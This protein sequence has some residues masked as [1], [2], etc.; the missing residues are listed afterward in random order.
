MDK[1]SVMVT[2]ASGS[3]GSEVLKAVM[4]AG[5]FKGIVLLRK[6]PSNEKLKIKL[7]KR[8]GED[9]EVVFGDISNYDDC[10]KTVA[11]SDYIIH[12][13]AVI[14]PVS[15]HHPEA[16]E[17]TNYIGTKNLVKAIEEDKN[18]A[19]KKFV[20]IGSVAEYGNRNFPAHWGRVGDPLLSSP[21]DYYAVTKIKGERAVVESG[22]KYWVSLRQSGILYDDV[23]FNNM[24]DGL[25][26]HTGWN[27]AIEWATARDSGRMARNLVEYDLDGKLPED[28]WQ[29]CYNIGNGD[30][31]RVTGYDTLERGFKMMGRGAKDIFRPH[32]NAH[33]NFHCFW[34][35]DSD[36]LNDYLNF[37]TES[38]EDFFSKLSKKLWYF[39][40]GKP[41]PGLI[42][43][44]AIERLFKDSNAPM[45]WVNHNIEGRIKAFYGSREQYEQIPRTWDNYKLL[46]SDE[47]R[48]ISTAE[49]LDLRGKTTIS[50]KDIEFIADNEY[51]GKNIAV[52][53]SHGYDESKPE[54]ELDIEDMRSAAK[55]RGG[56]LISEKMKKGD[57]RTKL[58]W[59]CHDGHKFS[60][61]PYTVIKAGFWCPECSQPVPWN[62]DA[63]SK[64]IPFFAQ[65][66][67]NSHS[68]EENEFYAADCYKDIL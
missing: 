9:I 28:F 1:K 30:K 52:I 14:P 44:F 46:P 43:K 3:M 67:Y 54:S 19:K 33:R 51:K 11:M 59:E 58:E 7:E 20:N 37:R 29:R 40:L 56:K 57:L 61:S 38:F 16:A 60:A 4:E 22:I 62:F 63:L 26:F 21:Y 64:K 55:F 32:W 34:Y 12:C 18:S 36:L 48:D 31:A 68:P 35:L 49:V 65:V 41:F 47:I 15:D 8:Y 50:E 42:R 23:L 45:Y 17:K 6:K 10:V 66:W 27:T 25:M 53:F 2:G 13:A 24:N 39:K 5:R